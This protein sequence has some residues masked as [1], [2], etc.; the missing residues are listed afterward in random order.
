MHIGDF[1]YFTRVNL[2]PIPC[3][4]ETSHNCHLELSMKFNPLSNPWSP[5]KNLIYH[6]IFKGFSPQN[7]QWKGCDIY[8]KKGLN[9]FH[10]NPD[11]PNLYKIKYCSQRFSEIDIISGKVKIIQ[12]GKYN[13]TKT[14]P[15]DDIMMVDSQKQE[16]VVI[17]P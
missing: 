2:A 6:L 9:A 10:L 15:L 8:M 14:L 16:I 7:G 3:N 5:I 17:A 4:K 12:L 11:N 13:K 1:I